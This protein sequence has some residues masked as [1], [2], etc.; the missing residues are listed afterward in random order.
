MNKWFIIFFYV[1]LLIIGFINRD[2]LMKWIQNSDRSYLFFMFLLSAMLAI[3]PVIPFT[4]F[5]GIMGVKFGLML[6]LLIN[7]FGG[8]TAAITYYLV[9]RFIASDYFIKKIKTY[10]K[11]EYLNHLVKNNS[12]IAVLLGRLI[13]VIPPPAVHIYSAVNGISFF[14]YL[15]ATAIGIIPPMFIV[16]FGGNQLFTDFYLFLVGIFGY[17][18]FL[19]SVILFSRIWIK[20]KALL[21]D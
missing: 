17:L 2:L 10:K 15:L 6:G 9:A 14:T 18:I 3:F 11:V 13:P 8:L 16:S 12:F 21:N 5:G 20:R 19:V 4:L 7:W 1:I